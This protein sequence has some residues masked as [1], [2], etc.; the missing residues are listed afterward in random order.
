MQ[1]KSGEIYIRYIVNYEKGKTQ[2]V[3]W[4]SN[5]SPNESRAIQQKEI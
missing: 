3:E 2:L 1:V 4:S 5:L